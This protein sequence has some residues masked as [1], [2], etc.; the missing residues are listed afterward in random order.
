L[1]QHEDPDA[2]NKEQWRPGNK[3]W[4]NVTAG[5]GLI[6]KLIDAR[7]AIDLFIGFLE[8]LGLHLIICELSAVFLIASIESDSLILLNRYVL[9]FS[10]ID[11]R[12]ESCQ[13]DCRRVLAGGIDEFVEE[14][15]ACNNQQPE[16]YLSSSRTQC[17]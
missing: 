15:C 8:Q 3:H 9:Y 2:D 4:P 17:H 1:P 12:V 14:Q 5:A 7:F 13:V 6:L 11:F 16:D 10:L